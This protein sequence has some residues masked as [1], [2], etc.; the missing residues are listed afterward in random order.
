M[1]GKQL[2]EK[3]EA[4]QEKALKKG[5]NLK[6]KNLFTQNILFKI[7]KKEEKKNADDA[8]EAEEVAQIEEQNELQEMAIKLPKAPK[9][10]RRYIDFLLA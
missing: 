7:G 5:R 4:P 9:G 6:S 10:Q 1:A 3:K 8:R 2:E